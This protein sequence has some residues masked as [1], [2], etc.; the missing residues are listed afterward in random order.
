[1]DEIEEIKEKIAEEKLHKTV[2]Y[3]F[4][5]IITIG[6]L[7]MFGFFV[8]NQ[9]HKIGVVY[10]EFPYIGD[11]KFDDSFTV[12]GNK[13]G[14]VKN[15]Y[16]NEPNKVILTINLKK[17]IEIHKGYKL[18]IGDVGIFGERVVCIEN[19][20]KQSPIIDLADTLQGVYYPGISDMLGRIQ[21][22]RDFLDNCM[23]FVNNI[24]H[25]TDSSRSIIE[26]LNSTEKTIDKIALSGANTLQNLDN[27]LPEILSNINRF[28]DNFNS[29]MTNFGKKLPD[30]LE[31]TD[32]II[33][34]C[35]TL[36]AKITKIRELGSDAKNFAEKIDTID[37]NSLNSTILEWQ[38]KITNISNE[39]FKLRLWINEFRIFRD[40]K[41]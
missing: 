4:I 27:D 39:A 8:Y 2:G 3:S 5:L 41:E 20:P 11:V 40:F 9:V 18:F 36:L 38:E 25:G 26:W 21:E 33:S 14:I 17:P 30:I 28:S 31:K 6:F 10:C 35:D 29:D 32:A 15:I 12:N 22:L 24:Q 19:G 13:V 23:L 1:M 7:A 37:I 16:S 34:D